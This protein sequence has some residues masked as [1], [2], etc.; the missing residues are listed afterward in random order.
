L[1]R[2]NKQ[3]PVPPPPPPAPALPTSET[4]SDWTTGLWILI[5]YLAVIA[6]GCVGL[7]SKYAWLAGQEIA[8]DRAV[9]SVINAATLT[10][11]PMT[12]GMA[13]MLPPG[14]WTIAA[15]VLAGG[16]FTL[17]A[18]ACAV[19]AATGSRH[20][21]P[22]IA[23]ASFIMLAIAA[24]FGACFLT[25]DTSHLGGA[26]NGLSAVCNCGLV[27]GSPPAP[28][29]LLT[30][31]VR[32]PMAIL[33]G[34]GVIVIL[35]LLGAL[36]GK[37]ISRHTWMMLLSAACV[38][39]IGTV[40]LGF[41]LWINSPARDSGSAFDW[42]AVALN[43]EASSAWCL[44]SRTAGFLPGMATLP[45][46]GQW[47]V[48]IL[49]AIGATSGGT[50]GGIK[51][52]TLAALFRAVRQIWRG[53]LPGRVAV[54]AA[55]ALTG[56][57]LLTGACLLGLVATTDA[58]PPDRLLIISVSA[59][60]NVGMSFDPITVTGP[61][62]FIISGTMLLGRLLPLTMLWWLMRTGEKCEYAVG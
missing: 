50:A 43:A 36:A 34:L 10:G 59:A 57:A 39:L 37:A 13:T 32:L 25:A 8:P 2:K 28:L 61:G 54:V 55:A 52:N 19:A 21:P 58:L 7:L 48:V 47:V 15:L 62:L 31:A 40:A 5:T 45:R 3:P 56:W 51:S 35:D 41:I 26:F 4:A 60:S 16:L 30:H 22:A 49:M 1:S 46:V 24:I 27:M 23:M 9:F 6:W 29:D 44:A 33:G 18:G 38:Y 53:N 11:F 20:R 12:R 14:Q 42:H 17:W